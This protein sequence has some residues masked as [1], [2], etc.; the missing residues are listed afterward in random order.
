[1]YVLSWRGEAIRLERTTA[2]PSKSPERDEARQKHTSFAS[3]AIGRCPF[4][5]FWCEAAS[6]GWP[7]PPRLLFRGSGA[8]YLPA[9]LYLSRGEQSK[10]KRVIPG[11]NHHFPICRGRPSCVYVCRRLAWFTESPR[12]CWIR[13]D[14][15]FL[16]IPHVVAL[17]LRWHQAG[18]AFC[19]ACICTI[20]LHWVGNFFYCEPF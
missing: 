17:D 9:S 6:T 18:H 5:Y 11:A 7:S 3:P 8:R 2:S 19:V 20:F 16:W 4:F 15:P 10:A 12:S 13:L 1:M 14:S